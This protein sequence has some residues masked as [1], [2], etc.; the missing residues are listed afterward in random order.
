MNAIQNVNGQPLK[1]GKDTSTERQAG[2]WQ[3]DAPLL[4]VRDI[5]KFYA[6]GKGCGDV[7]FDLYP[8]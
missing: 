3:D 6:P 2:K 7:S 5:C 4:S 8:G 1:G